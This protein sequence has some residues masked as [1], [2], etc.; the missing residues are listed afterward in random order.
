MLG[1]EGLIDFSLLLAEILSL[2]LKLWVQSLF[3]YFIRIDNFKETISASSVILFKYS[4]VKEQ[5][6][7]T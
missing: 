2:I 7:N 1:C 6:W 3:S 5:Y 4:T